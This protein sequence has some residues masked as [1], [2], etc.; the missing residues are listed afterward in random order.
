MSIRKDILLRVYFTFILLALVG[1]AIFGRA[2][3][4]QF[5]QGNKW[6][7]MSDSLTTDFIDVEAG[8]GNIYSEDGNLLATS[9]PEYEIRMD[10]KTETLTKEIFDA[11]VDSLAICL[12]NLFQDKSADEYARK[13]IKARREGQ[14]Y[15]LLK[16][17]INYPQLKKVK[18]FPIFRMGKN[19]GGLLVIQKNKRIQ[20]YKTLASRTIGYKVQGVQP[21]GLEGAFDTE[22]GGKTGKRLVQRISGGVWMPL[23]E[24]DEIAPQDGYD[25]ITTI[26]L[27]IQDVAQNAL[28]E[29]LIKHN[30]DHGCVVLMEVATGE[31]KAIANLTR[32]ETGVYQ[33]KY[34]YA[35]GEATEPGSTFKLASYMAALEDEIFT[36]DDTV[37]TDG[38]KYKIYSHTL[39]DSHDGGFGRIPMKRAFEVSSNVAIAK[40]IHKGYKEN[41][42]KFVE[43]LKQFGLNDKIELQIPGTPKPRVKTPESSDWS[44]LSL[45]LLS[46]GYEIRM[47]PMQTLVLYNAVANN[48]K[49]VS[50]IIVKEMKSM[51]QTIQTYETKVLR[52]K[53]CSDKTLAIV[54]S[55]MEGVVKEGTAKNLSTTVYQIAGKTG[56]A[57]VAQGTSGYKNGKR[58][59]LASFCGY[60]PADNPK[61]SMIVVVSD[62]SASGYYGN[63][64]AGPIFK[65]IAD[66]VYASR[67]DMHKELMVNY[68]ASTREIPLAKA[69]SRDKIVKVYDKIG[70]SA[71]AQNMDEDWVVP[72]RKDNAIALAAKEN[73]KGLVPDV[74]GMGLQDALFL[75]E[76]SGLRTVVKGSG[77]VVQQSLAAGQSIRKGANI[78]I[79]LR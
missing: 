29:Q 9:L 38:G 64:V 52:K 63:V 45:P 19:K 44:G 47:T 48:G 4:I 60:F 12:A 37:D 27:N 7:K 18:E 5:F 26:D 70:V 28:N 41:P 40:K 53:I 14:R 24:E 55:M 46:I 79:E 56:T 1:V 57:Q 59:Y 34:N 17:A 23:N 42:E 11:N 22:L 72:Q 50:P 39:K 13:L 3:H 71:H 73:I 78:I 77:K 25:I 16:R 31:V 67:L 2:V 74:K 69:G 36:P 35:I 20:P 30:A 65:E 49:M 32:I 43:R 68:A 8:R 75:L 10:L 54:K 58:Q 62:P 76:N 51:G 61:Y 15:L 21:V 33:E 66:K 6:K